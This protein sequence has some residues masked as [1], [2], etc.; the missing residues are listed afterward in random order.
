MFSCLPYPPS[1]NHYWRRACRHIHISTEGR[2]YRNA[3]AEHLAGVKATEGRLA[4]HIRLFPPDKRRRDI[5]NVQKPLLDA[6]QHGG[7]F[8]DDGQIDWLLTERKA[9]VKGGKV[10]VNVRQ[11]DE[12][13]CHA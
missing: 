7:A 5:D 9:V 6:L 13:P 8:E 1:I 11:I 3:V 4:V 2:N 10:E 12:V